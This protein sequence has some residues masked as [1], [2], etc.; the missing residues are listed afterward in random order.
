MLQKTIFKCPLI[1]TQPKNQL[2]GHNVNRIANVMI[3]RSGSY[4]TCRW[5]D[6][7]LMRL[8]VTNPIVDYSDSKPV[9]FDCRF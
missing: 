2:L 5:P 6:N 3:S 4:S 7:K 8:G 9:D 1:E